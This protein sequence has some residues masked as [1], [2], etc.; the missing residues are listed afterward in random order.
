MNSSGVSRGDREPH[1]VPAAG[2]HLREGLE[3][4]TV[5]SGS[6]LPLG[7]SQQGN[8]VN[9]AVFSRHATRVCLELYD[10]VED[11]S[12]SNVVQLTRAHHRTGDIWHVWI[13][14][15]RSGQLYAYRA[16]GPYC[17][18]EGHRFNAHKLLLDPYSSALAGPQVWDFGPAR[19]YDPASPQGDRSC[20]EVD[21]AG[22]MPKCIV[23]HQPF[24]WAGDQPLRHPWSETAIYELHVRGFTID[25]S[26]GVK[27]PG[28]YRGLTEK[29]PYLQQLGVTAVELM[30]V[31]EFNEHELTRT[32]PITGERLCNYWGYSPVSFFAP[33]ASYCSSGRL[34]Q[35][36]T[37]FREM[38]KAFHQAR[39]E[40]I[41]DVV[42]NH[43]AEGDELG[44]TISFRGLD[45]AIYY[46]LD[47][48]DRSYKDFS[49]TGNTLNANHPV[50]RDLILDALRHW[51]IEM[52][53][54]GFRF[55]LASILGRDEQ[56]NLLSNAP[57]LERIA[58]DPILREVKIIAEAWDAAGAYQVGSFSERR[59]AEW[60]ARY[61][62]DVRRFWRGDAGM[63]GLF[64][65]RIC[66][67][68]DVYQGSG[69][70][71]ESSIN[72]VTCHDGFT[73]NDLV[74][75]ER[76]HNEVNGEGNRDG[77]DANYSA[78]YGWEGPTDDAEIESIRVR[79]IKNLLLTL[80]VSRGVPMLSAGDEFRRSQQGNNNAYCQDNEISWCDWS[81]LERYR[82]IYRFARAM[83]GFRRAHP[84]LRK[85]MF[86][87]GEEIR[88]FGPRGG[89]PDWFDPRQKCLA[90]VISGQGEP[91]LCLMFN[92]ATEQVAFSLP[93]PPGRRGW[94][95]VVDTTQPMPDG[96]LEFGNEVAL[97]DMTTYDMGPRSSVILVTRAT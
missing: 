80:F 8:G 69:K 30:P 49:G 96:L 17:P 34:G 67:S 87:N 37:E 24:D 53:V 58:E 10:H 74:S 81:L 86:Y 79:Q 95:L 51:V 36:I 18:A 43:T 93:H 6:P 75:Y 16:E 52:H 57:L 90:C 28:T 41:L 46:L 59:W 62:D 2:E 73:L 12:P 82:E 61:R 68:A 97:K 11:A 19:G 47:V 92:A 20:S 4:G 42:F 35:Q 60:N 21:D 9:F 32:N 71:P 25:R 13:R 94:W 38:I 88:W 50:V 1:E 44:P 45:N 70:G 14:G 33:K 31:Q 40:V 39:M 27:H 23:L 54:D 89:E 29:I 22:I 3:T 55:D 65:S 72:Y 7:T 5:R 76:K 84:T 78:N 15:L 26:S 56:G 85:E 64:A 63:L 48:S 83:I 77:T 91:D 66:G